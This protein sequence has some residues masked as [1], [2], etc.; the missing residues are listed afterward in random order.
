ME[1]RLAQNFRNRLYYTVFAREGH[2][3]SAPAFAKVQAFGLLRCVAIARPE[4]DAEI[5]R[6]QGVGRPGIESPAC[7]TD[8]A[9][10]PSFRH[11]S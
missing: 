6:E 11:H 4:K 2:Y 9:D 10:P 1:G 7:L 3:F 5:D 8:L